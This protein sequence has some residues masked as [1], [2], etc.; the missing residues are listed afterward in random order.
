MLLET[1]L[2]NF[3]NI[4]SFK[5][6]QFKKI[7]ETELNKSEVLKYEYSLDKSSIL[8]TLPTGL[9]WTQKPLKIYTINALS[10][11]ELCL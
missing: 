1:H 11:L 10:F 2:K 6:F 5:W 8:D 9:P 4:F 7:S 3:C